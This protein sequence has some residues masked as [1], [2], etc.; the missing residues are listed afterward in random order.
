V[1][2]LTLTSGKVQNFRPPTGHF[3]RETR[4]EMCIPHSNMGLSDRGPSNTAEAPTNKYG[5]SGSAKKKK[6]GKRRIQKMWTHLVRVKQQ[7]FL[8]LLLFFF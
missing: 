7:S 5:P 8:N 1:L 3:F 4:K 6:K 2:T